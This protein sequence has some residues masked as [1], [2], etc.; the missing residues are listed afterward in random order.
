MVLDSGSN[1]VSTGE[2]K[3]PT[4]KKGSKG[5]SVKALQILLMGYGFSCGSFGADGDFGA[6]TESA[7]KAYQKSK[8][9]TANGQAGEETWMRLLGIG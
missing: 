5:L 1:G 9:L 4:L 6:A 2:W 8:N 7:L 3:L